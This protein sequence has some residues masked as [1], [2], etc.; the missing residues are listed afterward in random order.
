M[1]PQK[2]FLILTAGFGEGHNSAARNLA[3]SLEELGHLADV[4][5]PCAEGAPRLNHRLRKWY[6]T[7]TTRYPLVWH[8]VYRRTD[9]VDFSKRR[10]PLMRKVERAMRNKIESFK[11]DACI[12]TYPLYPYFM[13]RLE[14]RG[15]VKI[16]HFVVVT[17]S[18]EINAAWRRAPGDAFLLTD[19]ATSSILTEKGMDPGRLKV[20][21][22]PV[23][24][25]FCRLSPIR[26]EDFDGKNFRVLYFAT[27]RNSHLRRSLRALLDCS[28]NL[29]ITVVLGRNVR[30]LYG[31]AKTLKDEHP[32][33]VKI[34]GWT[35]KVPELMASHHLVVGKAGGATVHEALA[36][37]CPMLVHHLVP[38]QEEGNTLLL[39]HLGVGALADTDEKL[40]AETA[41]M[42]ANHA[43]HWRNCK[44]KLAQ[45]GQN[46]GGP[47]SAA[48]IIENT[49]QKHDISAH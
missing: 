7:V 10:N 20:S 40:R 22:F 47:R 19:Q 27:S 42:L 49:P 34:K 15:Y 38:G 6:R 3:A 32:G 44:R 48:F 11:P 33:R 2:R 12:S 17:D 13:I 9:R 25:S 5:D 39:E 14:E 45:L 31:Q 37:E 30:N 35:T 43:T 29:E 28:E 26:E 4:F 16:P 24:P 1:P 8:W 36:A 41:R 46:A 23:H 21:G 18:I